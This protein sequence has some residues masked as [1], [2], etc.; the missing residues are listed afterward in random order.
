LCFMFF[1]VSVLLY[2]PNELA[3]I[4]RK[5]VVSLSVIGVLQIVFLGKG[6]RTT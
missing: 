2:F 5:M 3:S 1:W 4:S 6:G